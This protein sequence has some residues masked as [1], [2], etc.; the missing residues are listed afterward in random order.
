MFS[1]IVMAALTFVASSI[2]TVFG[3]SIYECGKSAYKHL[4]EEDEE[5]KKSS[6]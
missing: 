2:G 3:K 4:A 5:K 1:S 6:Q